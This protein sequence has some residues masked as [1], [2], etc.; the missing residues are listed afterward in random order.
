MVFVCLFVCC[1][2]AQGLLVI[3]QGCNFSVM[4][5]WVEREDVGLGGKVNIS[6]SYSVSV[7][8]NPFTEWGGELSPEGEKGLSSQHIISP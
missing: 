3:I 5:N 8:R 1:C 4:E 7:L 6:P 2:F